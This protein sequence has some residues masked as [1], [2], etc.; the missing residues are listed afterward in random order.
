[1]ASNCQIPTP[2]EYVR[3]MLDAANYK[4]DL[5]GKRVLENSCGDG[6]ILV[7]VI[8]RYISDCI[9]CGIDKELIKKGLSDDIVGYDLDKKCIEQTLLRLKDIEKKYSL[10][11]VKWNVRKQD[12]LV[13]PKEYYDFIIGNPPYI[14][15]HDLTEGQREFLN[16]N[17]Q[18]CKN[19]RFDYCYAF[20][21][22]S[23][24]ELNE[25]GKLVYLVPYSVIRN[26]SARVLRELMLVKLERIY[27]YQGVRVFDGIISSSIIIV[28]GKGNTKSIT[29]YNVRENKSMLLNK[30]C[31]GNKWTFEKS[32]RGKYRFGDYFEICNSIATLCNDVFI[33]K[34]YIEDGEYYIIN[35]EV[36][37]KGLVYDAISANSIRK[38]SNPKII[39][40]YNR[41]NDIVD[42]ISEESFISIYP[43][44]YKYLANKK[45]RL[46]KR[47]VTK[48]IEWYEY[49]RRQAINNMFVPK[50]VMPM[51][52]GK[53]IKTYLVDEYAIPYAGYVVRCIP[54]KKFNLDDAKGILESEE[55]YNYVKRC[56]TPTTPHSYRISVKDISDYTFDL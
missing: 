8:E 56:G 52:L 24:N 51:I 15:Y 43:N 6:N 30:D 37:E 9:R 29:H 39:F 32:I 5:Y 11:N 20:I 25:N 4:S 13:Y 1:M 47:K 40:P 18:S 14:T 3:F 48:G 53:N 41:M 22:K 21:E 2:I 23:L 50:L 26:N 55:F 49:G 44:T 45:E 38:K 10:G 27:D 42:R 35:N 28:C 16:N 12:Y 46:M 17:F 54:N 19:G 7:E 36:I 33:I 34:N 31:L